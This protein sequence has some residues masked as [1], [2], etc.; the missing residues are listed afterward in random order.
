M[1]AISVITPLF[2]NRL[3]VSLLSFLSYKVNCLQFVQ[4]IPMAIPSDIS[5]PIVNYSLSIMYKNI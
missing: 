3:D 2:P 5:Y 4:V 1:D